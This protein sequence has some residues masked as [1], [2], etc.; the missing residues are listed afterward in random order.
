MKKQAKKPISK[1]T[2]KELLAEAKARSISVPDGALK[3]DIISLLTG[4]G[5][6]SLTVASKPALSTHDEGELRKHHR[7]HESGYH[8]S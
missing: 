5:N 7:R 3:K 4:A 1:M 8:G 6:T 2:A